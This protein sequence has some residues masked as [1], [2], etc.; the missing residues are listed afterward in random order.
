[1]PSLTNEVKKSPFFRGARRIISVASTW[2][3]W[4]TPFTKSNF[5]YL[6]YVFDPL[7]PNDPYRGRTAPLTSKVAFYIFIQ[8]I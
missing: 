3:D 6:R 4:T 8:Q 1:M 7:T 2:A 5:G